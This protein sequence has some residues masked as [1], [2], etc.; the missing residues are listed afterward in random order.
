MIWLVVFSAIFA[1]LGVLA[2]K[3][4]A[5]ESRIYAKLAAISLFFIS[6]FFAYQAV[7]YIQLGADIA[8]FYNDGAGVVYNGS[9][10]LSSNDTQVGEYFA[11][12]RANRDVIEIFSGI[13]PIL[14]TLLGGYLLW[15]YV[16]VG[17]FSRDNDRVT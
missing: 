10:F 11:M 12:Q 1:G 9:V 13:L 6:V 14:A 15:Y 3:R 8:N 17:L 16:E 7:Y 2:A 4:A 5:N